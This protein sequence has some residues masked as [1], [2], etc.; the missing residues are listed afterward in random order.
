MSTNQ[1]YI[2]GLWQDHTTGI[3][4][5]TLSHRAGGIFNNALTIYIDLILIQ[6]WALVQFC[7]F[8][9]LY[10]PNRRDAFS[11]QI[12][13]L[14]RSPRD[15]LGTLLDIIFTLQKPW[16]KRLGPMAVI[17]RLWVV[18]ILCI[19]VYVGWAAAKIFVSYTQISTNNNIRLRGSNCGT[20]NYT[21]RDLQSSNFSE[22]AVLTEGNAL[23]STLAADIYSQSC[24]LGSTSNSCNTFI[25]AHLPS[26]GNFTSCPFAPQLCHGGVQPYQIASDD[27][28]SLYSLGILSKPEDRA[29]YRRNMTCSIIHAGS[30]YSTIISAADGGEESGRPP[31][32]KLVR[33]NFGPILQ[34]GQNW[35]LEYSEDE[36]LDDIGYDL[37]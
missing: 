21:G 7:L 2:Y 25:Q 30:E 9:I 27:V 32:D 37:R 29:I 28:D 22:Q 11:R 26:R 13:T 31:D 33:I 35:T 5:W 20:L 19:V 16:R 14:I 6:F 23:K 4:T 12:Q 8:L 17:R 24:Y 34:L 1:R 18:T 36:P 10:G 3:W 15:S